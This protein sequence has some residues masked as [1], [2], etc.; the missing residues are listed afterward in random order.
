MMDK[1]RDALDRLLTEKI[2]G[3]RFR[4]KEGGGMNVISDGPPKRSWD[5]VSKASNARKTGNRQVAAV[6]V[7]AAAGEVHAVDFRKEASNGRGYESRPK[8]SLCQKCKVPD[9]EEAQCPFYRGPPA[10]FVCNYCHMDSYHA[11]EACVFKNHVSTQQQHCL[12]YTSP[13][14]RDKRQSRMPSS[15]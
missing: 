12:L 5:K 2:N 13:S 14:P 8:G 9:H 6:S 10:K 15:A 7:E 3:W 1:D 11:R 4:G